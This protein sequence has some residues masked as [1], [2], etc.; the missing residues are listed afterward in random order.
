MKK[1]MAPLQHHFGEGVLPPTDLGATACSID[2]ERVGGHD[3][4]TL[5]NTTPAAGESNATWNPG[6]RRSLAVSSSP[7]SN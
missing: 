2:A 1:K 4:V 6:L 5:A 7:V 3:G